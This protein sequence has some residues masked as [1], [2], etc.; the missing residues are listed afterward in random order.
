LPIPAPVEVI[1]Y[2]LRITA[3]ILAYGVQYFFWF[4][5]FQVHL[6]TG[7]EKS[8]LWAL[9]L[10]FILALADE[11]HQFL[12]ASRQGRVQDVA[13]DLVGVILA[14]ILLTT[15]SSRRGRLPSP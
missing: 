8:L 7:R 14:A 3:H 15:L 13:L 11:G 9:G 5:A 12:V 10:C 4:R 2:F 1:H 6:H